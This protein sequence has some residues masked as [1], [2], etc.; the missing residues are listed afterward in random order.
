[1]KNIIQLFILLSISACSGSSEER[2]YNLESCPKFG[3]FFLQIYEFS[4]FSSNSIRIKNK[5]FSES[6]N[7]TLKIGAI[8]NADLDRH[9]KV[10]YMLKSITVNTAIFE[11]TAIF[12]ARS[13]GGKAEKCSGNFTT[14][15]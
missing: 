2:T 7:D 3:Q 12:D 13:F 5:Q 14:K 1:M 10:K 6:N 11:Y 8:V 9:T 15:I 4:A